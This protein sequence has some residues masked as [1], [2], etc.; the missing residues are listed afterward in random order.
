MPAWRVKFKDK[1]VDHEKLFYF[2]RKVWYFN[3]IS[4]LR[5]HWLSDLILFSLK[6]KHTNDG[7]DKN[8]LIL[9]KGKYSLQFCLCE[10]DLNYLVITLCQVMVQ[11]NFSTN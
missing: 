4:T 8:E 9:K 5:L 10:S 2:R 11:L 3:L 6:R 7:S 1:I